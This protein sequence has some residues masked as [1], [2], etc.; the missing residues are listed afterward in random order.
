[1]VDLGKVR[2]QRWQR[3]WRIAQHGLQFGAPGFEVVQPLV[4]SG[5]ACP[6]GDGIDQ[7]CYLSLYGS[8]LT[9]LRLR[10]TRGLCHQSVPFSDEGGHKLPDE[11]GPHEL[12]G[13]P[14]QDLRLKLR[15]AD[16]GCV[17]AGPLARG[18]T[19]KIVLPD[20]GKELTAC[21]TDNLAGQQKART[22]MLP[23]RANSIGLRS[24]SLQAFEP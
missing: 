16:P 22:P 19:A 6:L 20:G 5:A 17:P 13:Q 10:R 8:Q 14:V 15:S 9:L 12:L 7:I 21:T 24:L 4:H 11:I 1:V 3:R 18:A 23:E 2:V